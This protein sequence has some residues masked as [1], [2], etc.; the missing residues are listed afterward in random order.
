MTR[1]AGSH[2]AAWGDTGDTFASASD[3]HRKG[4]REGSARYSG[5][6]S[7]PPAPHPWA[8][9]DQRPALPFLTRCRLS[10]GYLPRATRSVGTPAP[11]FCFLLKTE[12]QNHEINGYRITVRMRER[13]PS[14][15]I[16]DYG[17]VH[18]KYRVAQCRQ[19]YALSHLATVDW[20]THNSVAMSR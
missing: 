11:I 9:P 4:G 10:A 14:G 12:K 2:G 19:H 5:G 7:P 1:F 17:F 13:N 20:L 6:I 15:L 3:V 16:P 18:Q 8:A